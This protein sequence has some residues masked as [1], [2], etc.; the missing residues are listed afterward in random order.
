MV[1]N[2]NGRL[3]LF[4][5]IELIEVHLSCLI[6]TLLHHLLFAMNIDVKILIEFD[7]TFHEPRLLFQRIFG[8]LEILRDLDI[9]LI[10][11][12]ALVF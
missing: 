5:E 11:K 7:H 10:A 8:D 2:R 1:P 3:V 12:L 6:E 4:L 9:I